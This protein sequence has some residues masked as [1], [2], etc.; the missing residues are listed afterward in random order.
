MYQQWI[1]D[2]K[3]RSSLGSL[4][5]TLPRASSTACEVKFSDGI[6]LMK[7]FCRFFSYCRRWMLSLTV[8]AKALS[9]KLYLFDYRK[10]GRIGLLEVRGEELRY[11]DVRTGDEEAG[12]NVRTCCWL[13][14]AMDDD[15]LWE[16]HA[17]REVTDL[18]VSAGLATT[19]STCEVPRR[20]GRSDITEAATIAIG[21]T[22]RLN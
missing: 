22:E 9:R 4:C 11:L 18:D 17:E 14:S 19:R 16:D 15:A 8:L 1:G 6:R 2:V 21:D 20:L 7:C 5:I 3:L 12:Q 10:H 13:S